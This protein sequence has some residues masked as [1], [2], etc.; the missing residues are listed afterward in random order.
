MYP[1]FAFTLNPVALFVLGVVGLLL[2]GKDLPLIIRKAAK[3]YYRYKKLINEATADIRGELESAANQLE[4]EKRKLQLEAEASVPSLND[5]EPPPD[6]PASTEDST[7]GSENSIAPPRP[8]PSEPPPK[9]SADPLA[10]DVPAPSTLAHR[11][12]ESVKTPAAQ[13]AALDTLQKGVP[14]PSKIPPP[15]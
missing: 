4:E 9:P 8:A 6:T 12:T 13:A 5:S 2:Y 14:P 7:N 10:L 3:E 1:I 11:A 15:L